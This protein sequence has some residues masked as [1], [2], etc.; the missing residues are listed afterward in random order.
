[1]KK[2]IRTDLIKKFLSFSGLT[3]LDFANICGIDLK[4]FNK[5]M[6]T[7][8]CCRLSTLKSMAIAMRVPLWVLLIY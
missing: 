8:N 5:I 6:D 2:R 4:T 7:Q 3:S 1:M